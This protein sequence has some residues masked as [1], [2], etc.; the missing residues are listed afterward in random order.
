[1]GDEPSPS[2]LFRLLG[3]LSTE[4]SGL[5]Q[6]LDRLVRVDLYE[7]HRH[8][9]TAD[10][11]R[12]EADVAAVRNALVEQNREREKERAEQDRLRAQDQAANKR[13]L[14]GAAI[15]MIATIIASVLVQV[16]LQ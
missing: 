1:M 2:E 5:H 3:R 11:R 14:W 9:M 16:I 13:V 6:A 12:I 7:A 15:G 10:M 4:I 8:A